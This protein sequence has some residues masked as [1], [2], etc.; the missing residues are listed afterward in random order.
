MHHEVSVGLNGVM[1]GIHS[2]VWWDCGA[3]DCTLDALKRRVHSQHDGES[4]FRKRAAQKASTSES[5]HFRKRALQ[6]ASGSE[7]EQFRK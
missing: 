6:E 1:V 3:L 2:T 7:S 4:E 5:E